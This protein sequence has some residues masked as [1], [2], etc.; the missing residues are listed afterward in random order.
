MIR[1]RL[2]VLKNSWQVLMRS[3]PKRLLL[4]V[5]SNIRAHI[6]WRDIIIFAIPIMFLTIALMAL[7]PGLYTSDSYDQYNQAQTG[8][9]Y[10]AHPVFHTF[11]IWLVN[12]VHHSQAMLPLFQIFLFS[13]LWAVICKYVRRLYGDKV[14][15]AQVAF[16]TIL[17]ALPIIYTYSISAWKDVLYSYSLLSLA[18]LLFV[19]SY[20]KFN[21]SALE[22]VC[23]S[24]L[25]VLTVAY[26]LN[27]IVPAVAIFAVL[28]ICMV[29]YKV[30]TR[31]I[32]AMIGLSIAFYALTVFMPRLFLEVRTS[33]S[34]PK[35]SVSIFYMA[36]LMNSGAKIDD[37]DQRVL[38]KV[39]PKQYWFSDYY[40]YSYVPIGFSEHIN[41]K[42]ANKYTDQ[43]FDMVLK[44]GLRYPGISAEQFFEVNNMV[45]NVY[46]PLEGPY[47]TTPAI[48]AMPL[49]EAS[50]ADDAKMS[51][52]GFINNE[53]RLGIDYTL[54]STVMQTLF[55]RPALYMYLSIIIGAA[56]AFK[57]RSKR[58]WLLLLPMLF[59]LPAILIFG[60]TQDMRYLY[61]NVLTFFLIILAALVH[62]CARR[63][64]TI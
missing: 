31:K 35:T 23:A 50:L 52:L 18:F 24:I 26:R 10:T 49:T 14:F 17:C 20:K 15:Y 21:Y 40:Q 4:K 61:I 53:M 2:R 56:L 22:I 37:Q 36:G 39:M 47:K 46:W 30:A 63:K 9:V 3:D 1:F 29:R 44:Y 64:M 12:R 6:A 57:T 58:Y 19:G 45:W 25:L 42:A 7:W 51:K 27:G 33:E 59:N 13:L 11:T 60:L 62:L 41:H 38:Y 32:V 34:N 28:L 48:N 5:S 43:I 55:Y 54:D 8:I 16:M